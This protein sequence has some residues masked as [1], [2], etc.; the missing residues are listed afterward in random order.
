MRDDT[1]I[2][3]AGRDPE[4]QHGI[5]NPPV[6]HAST[7]LF[8]TLA[9]LEAAPSTRV[10]YGRRGTPTSFALEEAVAALEGG[11]GGVVMPSGLAAITVSLLAFLK[12]G[13]HLLMVDT[14]YDPVRTFCDG[15]LA[16]MGVEVTY[17]DPLIGGDVA[18]LIRP[19][20]RVVHTESPG[21]LTFEVQD[22][23][24]IATAAHATGAIVTHDTTWAS[25]LFFKPIGHGA[26]V[27]L[28]S[29]TKYI[30]GHSDVMMGVIVANDAT[31]R[32]VRYTAGMLGQCAG[33]DD[34]YLALRGLRTLSVRMA[35][36]QAS[37]LRIAS[38]LQQRDEVASVLYPALP[39]DP[40]HALWQRDFLGAS[41][42]FSIVLARPYPRAALAAM[43]DRM[44]LFGMGFSWGGFE[45][46]ILPAD[47]AAARSATTWQAS[48][49]L[50]RLHI[51]LEDPEDLLADLAD[52]FA[53]LAAA[54]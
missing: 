28:H 47:V 32:R 27:S 1:L 26:D 14:A 13:D 7:V 2:T 37:A 12:S 34:I 39:S 25:P 22:V 36:H 9:A 10:R 4:A 29:V 46:L 33:P 16:A 53:R 5:V 21:S 38:W 51:G 6:Y 35:R 50:L 54:S 41:G 43:L 8:P 42:L 15:M 40:G 49:P 30:G 24:A 11:F 20:T 48:G 19:N 52:G 45:S 3:T 23:P 18:E 31:Y 17:Y 44:R